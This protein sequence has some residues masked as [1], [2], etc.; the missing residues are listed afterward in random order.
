MLPDVVRIRAREVREV[1][2]KIVRHSRQLVDRSDALKRE[3]DAAFTAYREAIR[4]FGVAR[5]ALRQ[6]M[7]QVTDAQFGVVRE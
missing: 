2:R 1:S 3:I 5:A 4:E 6:A 7:R